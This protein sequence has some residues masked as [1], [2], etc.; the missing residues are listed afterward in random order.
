MTLVKAAILMLAALAAGAP[1]WAETKITVS[2]PGVE[3]DLRRDIQRQ[4][5]LVQAAGE[6]VTDPQELLALARAE[7]GKLLGYLY[8]LGHYAGVITVAVDGREAAEIPLLDSPES[9][10]RIAVIVRPG[11]LYRFDEVSVSPQAPGTEFP[12]TFAR[13]AAAGTG[14]IRDAAAAAVDGWRAEGHAKAAISGQ[15][16]V[17]RHPSRQVDAALTV[18]PGPLLNFGTVEVRG[19]RNVRTKRILTIAGL[20]EGRPF[21]PDEIARAERRLRRTGSFSSVVV[22]EAEE[23]V[24]DAY[25]PLTIAVAEQTPRRFGFGAEYSTIEGVRLSGFWLHRNFLGGAERFRVD[26]EI[27]GIGGETG[28]TDYSFGVRYE[29][30]ATPRADVDFYSSYEIARLEEPDYD[31]FTSDFQLGFTRYATDELVV[32]FGLGHLY[33]D[34]EDAFGPEIYSILTLPLGAVLD[35]RDDPLNPT[36]GVYVDLGITPYAGIGDTPGG[37]QVTLDARGYRTFGDARPTTAAL[38]F[39]LGSL[40]GAPLLESP[41][42]FRFYSGGGGT[43]RGQDYQSLAIDV[44]A[45]RTGGRSFV[46]LSAEARVAITEAIQAVGFYDWGYVGENALPDS[47]GDTH[48]GAGLGLR[49]NTGIGPIRLDLATPVSGGGSGVFIYVGIGQAF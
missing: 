23:V 1:A 41:P 40:A 13:G 7:Y 49:Y 8:S 39:Q 5:L 9:I 17:A 37:T 35:R 27:A 19:N 29:R 24:G 3:R 12:D 21:D 14:A 46:G 18:A 6:G 32:N 36:R 15:R 2:V 28:G 16:I 42:F 26:G 48:A 10:A 33:S 38:R 34:V 11:P 47:T 44:G 4:S 25:L 43:V 45:N 20:E 22:Q 31:S 30:P